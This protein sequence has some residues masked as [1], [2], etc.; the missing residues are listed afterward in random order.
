MMLFRAIK[1]ANTRLILSLTFQT[2]LAWDEEQVEAAEA[3]D[4]AEAPVEARRIKKG[5]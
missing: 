2:I 5:G 3:W 1:P 4:M